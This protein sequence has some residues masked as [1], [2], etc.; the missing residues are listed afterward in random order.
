[1]IAPADRILEIAL[2]EV[3]GGRPPPDL[4][5]WILARARRSSRRP[6]RWLIPATAAAALLVLAVLHFTRT[7]TEPIPPEPPPPIAGLTD[8][9]K[10]Q[11]TEWLALLRDPM[12]P[13]DIR[14]PEDLARFKAILQAG[15]DILDLLDET[16]EGWDWVRARI[17]PLPEG[18]KATP[19]RQRLLDV[20]VRRPGSEKDPLVLD[21]LRREGS[22]FGEETLLVLMERDFAPVRSILENRLA[23]Y[24]PV[25]PLALPAVA[26]ALTGDPRGERVLEQFLAVPKM[27]E[28]QPAVALACAAG[29]RA[30]GDPEAWIETVAGLRAFAETAVVDGDLDAAR[31]V[32][33]ALMIARP[34]RNAGATARLADLGRRSD[35]QAR[36]LADELKTAEAIRKR[37]AILGE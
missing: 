10:A 21:H 25:S 2:E 26:Y 3:V 1:M 18:P 29:L 19:I 33:A 32:V 22:A 15:R 16:P 20:L 24:P 8:A 36:R 11:T 23:T 7:P 17:L 4:E 35:R 30:L 5:E 13:S 28:A 6:L 12:G 34:L 9:Q 37:L 31:R 14:T 27:V